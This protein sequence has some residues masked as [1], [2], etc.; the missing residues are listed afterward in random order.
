LA[1]VIRFGHRR[2]RSRCAAA[3]GLALACGCSFSSF[4]SGRNETL[5][6]GDEESDVSGDT[7]PGASGTR[8]VADGGGDEEGGAESGGAPTSGPAIP[9]G[10]DADDGRF[11]LGSGATDD[12]SLPTDCAQPSTLELQIEDANVV[13]P[14]TTTDVDGVGLAAYSPDSDA[15]E[16]QFTVDVACP[17]TY[18]LHGFVADGWSGVHSWGDPDSY[19]VSWP[20]GGTT[21]FYGCQTEGLDEGWRWLPVMHGVEG[22]YCDEVTRAELTLGEGPNVIT[23]RNREGMTWDGY[24][25]AIAR[26]VVTNDA[27]YA[28]M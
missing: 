4:S 6:S 8:G 26:L 20:S 3:L 22:G 19:Y 13:A 14:M 24:V 12:G 21:W 23:V 28:P 15:G 7:R 9:P 25:A 1:E 5:G 27:A 2:H 18:Y 10:A 11:D 16:L 17:G